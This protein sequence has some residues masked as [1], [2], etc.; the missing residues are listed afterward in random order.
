MGSE[1]SSPQGQEEQH[2]DHNEVAEEGSNNTAVTDGTSKLQDLQTATREN[3]NKAASKNFMKEE[4]VDL[5]SQNTTETSPVADA[6]GKD[7]GKDASKTTPAAKSL[8]SLSFSRSV[9]SRTENQKADL[10]LESS[11]AESNSSHPSE[12]K[13]SAKQV[14]L[15]ETSVQKLQNNTQAIPS[16]VEPPIARIPEVE[17]TSPKTK[18]TSFFDTLFKSS[19]DQEKNK[20]QSSQQEVTASESL[21]PAEEVKLPKYRSHGFHKSGLDDDKVDSVTPAVSASV[22]LSSSADPAF[23]DDSKELGNNKQQ[24]NSKTQSPTEQSPIMSFFKT[25]GK[26][27]EVHS[28]ESEAEPKSSAEEKGQSVP[29]SK[30]Q[31]QADGS[32]HLETSAKGKEEKESSQR[33]FSKHFKQKAAKEQADTT[34]NGKSEKE[35]LPAQIVEPP[36]QDVKPNVVAPQQ[37]TAAQL[38]PKNE[39]TPAS[40]QES[41]SAQKSKEPEQNPFTKLFKIKDRSESSPAA[42]SEVKSTEVESASDALSPSKDESKNLD[43]SQKEKGKQPETQENKP[44]KMSFISFFQQL[45]LDFTD[46]KSSKGIEAAEKKDVPPTVE[47]SPSIQKGKGKVK[48]TKKAAPEKNQQN[49][50]QEAKQNQGTPATLQV[51]VQATGPESITD[52]EEDASK[53]VDKKPSFTFFKAKAAKEQADSTVNGKSEKETLPAQIMEPPKQDVK[54]IIVAPQQETAAQLEPKNESAPTNEQESSSAQK[55]KEPEQNIFTKLFKIKDRSESAPAASTDIKSLD[56]EFA[57][58]A[59]SSTKERS[60]SQTQDPTPNEKG[61]EPETDGNK[62]A[63]MSLMSFFRQLS[64]R[65]EVQS[66]SSTDAN[67]KDP[68]SEKLDFADGKNTKGVED[69]E[70]K[71]VPSGVESSPTNQKGKGKTKDA[72]KAAVEKSQQNDKQEG[73]PNQDIHSSLQ[74]EETEPEKKPSFASLFKARSVKKASDV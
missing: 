57:T 40:E 69:T 26:S 15:P 25:L 34:V 42:S 51:Q 59:L 3:Q 32:K 13:V 53:K 44:A 46:G 23:K 16:P 71:D 27:K 4:T 30:D 21:S 33:L 14:K 9:P 19:K 47:S 2:S 61:K 31:V 70:K 62:S 1:V 39:S 5:S 58:D 56:V 12:S 54:P 41:S 55:S 63:K 36:K 24:E 11:A 6:D 72:K 28:K 48:D 7:I 43:L 29:P 73:K 67:E 74:E 22:S 18:T 60:K 17:D 37:E 49:D 35:T 64:V 38:E 8:F 65:D 52:G 45:K 10:S 20:E 66:P 50:K 68:G